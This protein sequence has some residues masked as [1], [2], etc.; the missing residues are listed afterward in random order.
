MPLAAAFGF[1]IGA[2][3]GGRCAVVAADGEA[4]AVGS[5]SAVAMAGGSSCVVADG[6]AEA[7]DGGTAVAARD[8]ST[9]EREANTR[10][11]P[12]SAR[13][14]TIA[15]RIAGSCHHGAIFAGA[16]AGM[17]PDGKERGD[18]AGGAAVDLTP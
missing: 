6:T 10:T 4:D 15:P 3:A 17:R 2:A 8:E 12:P 14:P 7:V 1:A 13:R 16:T 9:R 11:I 5:G 18:D